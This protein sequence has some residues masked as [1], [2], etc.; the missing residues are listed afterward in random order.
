MNILRTTPYKITLCTD[1]RTCNSTTANRGNN[2]GRGLSWIY[3]YLYIELPDMIYDIRY[4]TQPAQLTRVAGQQT[5]RL[6]T[7]PGSAICLFVQGYV[8]HNQDSE[9]IPRRQNGRFSCSILQLLL[10]QTLSDCML[11]EFG[12]VMLQ[13]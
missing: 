4:M 13:Q 9:A 6:R 7:M 3:G 10:L 1:G 12:L 5:V 2:R 8:R 11:Q